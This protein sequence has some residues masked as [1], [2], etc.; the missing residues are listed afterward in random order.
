VIGNL[1]KTPHVKDKPIIP[2]WDDIREAARMLA[3]SPVPRNYLIQTRG[4]QPKIID[5]LYLGWHDNSI[6]IP[7]VANGEIVNVKTRPWSGYPKYSSVKDATFRYLYPYD[8]FRRNYS[9]PRVCYL[10][11]GELD[12]HLLLQEGLPAL[13]MPSGVNES[14]F[15]WLNVFK[16]FDRLD[17]MFDMDA[18]GIEATTRLTKDRN[19]LGRTFEEM[20]SPTVLN[21]W[22]WPLEWGKDI[23]EA[24][25]ML[26]PEIKEDYASI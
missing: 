19:R 16:Q 13:S 7:H 17:T 20:L 9:N 26:V 2:S 22:T 10:T 24:R 4:I 14:L 3:M 15:R 5:D 6:Y 23:G 18:P 11:E 25:E 1:S 21:T 8:Y 12:C